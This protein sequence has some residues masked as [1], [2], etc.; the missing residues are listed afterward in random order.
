[1][2]SHAQLLRGWRRDKYLWLLVSPV[3]IYYVVFH[4]IPM[5]GI[6]IAFKDFTA[7]KGI[8]GSPW[9]GMKWMNQFFDSMY[10]NR[11]FFNTLKLSVYSLLWG[12]PIPIL[13]ALLLNEVKDGL[14]K[15][16]TQSV[17]YLPHFISIVVICG[18]IL[19]FL[20]PSTG[21]V[22][23]AIQAI[24]LEPINFMS[25]S[26]W[27]RTIYI[28]SGIWQQFGWSSI[29]YIAAMASINPELYEA[30]T[31]DGADRWKQMFHI[32]LPGI[33]PTIMILLV[34]SFGSIL[35]VG[36]EKI[37]LLYNPTTYETADVISTYVYRRGLLGSEFSFGAAVSLFNS[38][39]NFVL[40]I[41]FN[42]LSKKFTEVS[43]W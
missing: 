24:G 32:T 39:I 17:S 21:I 18:M 22:N 41:T 31:C 14:F 5:Y 30:S 25:E 23:M 33:F 13:F 4:Y 8:L 34:L 29:I 35:S 28:G 43:L 1:M 20:S 11:L 26:G 27:F 36:F 7:V 38:V 40:L 15:K 19:T 42:W 16:V 6:T 10:F 12:F 2:R 9:V 3:L 37:I